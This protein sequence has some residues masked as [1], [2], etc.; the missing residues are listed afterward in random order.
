MDKMSEHGSI[1]VN[2]ISI[3]PSGQRAMQIRRKYKVDGMQKMHVSLKMNLC[4]IYIYIFFLNLCWL[5]QERFVED[6]NFFLF[7]Q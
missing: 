6:N 4:F 3:T 1:V 7:F 2:D 5:N